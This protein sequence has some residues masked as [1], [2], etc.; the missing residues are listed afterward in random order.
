MGFSRT[1]TF[2]WRS[3]EELVTL[4]FAR[5][6]VVLMNE[7]HNGLARCVRTREVGRCILPAAHAAG[8]RHL[9]MEALDPSFTAIANRTRALPQLPRHGGYLDQPEMRALIQTALDLGWTLHCYEADL[10]TWLQARHGYTIERRDGEP[11]IKPAWIEP[12]RRE[13]MSQEYTNWREEQQALNLLAVQSTIQPEAKLLVWCGNGHL[14]CSGVDSWTPMG[15]HLIRRGCSVFAIDQTVTV[16]FGPDPL[17]RRARLVAHHAAA[18][19]AHGGTAGLLQEEL[20]AGERLLP[21]VDAVILSTEN[22]LVA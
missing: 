11:V 2:P 9:A 8:V 22:Q 7:A 4:G 6:P 13:M 17:R 16:A 14:L 5:A 18:L 19:A 15:A 1:K 20:P 3:P 10:G 12:H 21:D